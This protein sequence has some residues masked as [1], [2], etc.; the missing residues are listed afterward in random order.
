MISLSSI[1]W[2]KSSRMDELLI[3]MDNQLRLY[4]WTISEMNRIQI[5]AQIQNSTRNQ[6]KK[7]VTRVSHYKK[8]WRDRYIKPDSSP[9]NFEGILQI[10]ITLQTDYFEQNSKHLLVLI[11]R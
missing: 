3:S 8:R 5:A 6:L 7:G 2:D 10:Q 1:L 9:L 4:L 11:K